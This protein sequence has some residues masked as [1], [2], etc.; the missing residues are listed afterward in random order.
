MHSIAQQFRYSIRQLA[1]SPGFAIVSILTLALGIG[2]NIAVFSV[3]NAVL[4][5]PS[6]IPHSANL[7]ALRAHY[8]SP[9]DLGNIS[10]SPPDFSPPDKTFPGHTACRKVAHPKLS[11]SGLFSSRQLHLPVLPCPNTKTVA[12]RP[13][14]P[15][16][17]SK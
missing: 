15:R 12:S 7:V 8:D 11:R 6:G 5:N 16:R 13:K 3:T 17:R 10:L 9:P 2:A 1:N 4:L 14:G